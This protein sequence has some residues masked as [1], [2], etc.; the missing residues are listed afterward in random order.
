MK[1]KIRAGIA[2]AILISGLLFALLIYKGFFTETR[3]TYKVGLID[4][5][6]FYPIILADK[7]GLFK[8]RQVDVKIVISKDN[9]EMNEGF[10][11]HE[12]DMAY[13]AYAD[14]VLMRGRGA[15][16]KFI[17]VADYSKFDS[18]VGLKKIRKL[19]DLKGKTIGIGDINSFSEF[20]VNTLLT[21]AGLTENDIKF[22]LVNFFD[23][24]SALDKGEIQAGHT[25]DPELSKAL[26]KGYH[27]IDSAA[28][29]EG[30]VIDG[31]A[32]HEDLLKNKEDIK[33]ILSAF[34]EAQEILFSDPQKAA[35]DIAEVLKVDPA[36][37]LDAIRN[38]ARFIKLNE[39][40]NSFGSIEKKLTALPHATKIISS[41]FSDRGQLRNFVEPLD[42]LDSRIIDELAK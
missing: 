26:A 2:S 7:Y 4:W 35:G 38:G 32:I 23:I 39:A 9:P 3:R 40:Q 17:Q 42:I 30:S 10:R 24:T 28:N 12:S 22:K 14:Y 6:G 16:I 13:G 31:L 11:V 8:K 1:G 18:I 20:F 36:S 15:K 25:W 27:V 21:N 33:K 29:V 34:Y 41:F 19:S 5:P 37:I